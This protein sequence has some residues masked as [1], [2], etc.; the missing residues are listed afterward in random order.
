MDAR[1]HHVVVVLLLRVGG[2]DEAVA[3]GPRTGQ[4]NV[5]AYNRQLGRLIHHDRAKPSFIASHELP[6]DQDPEA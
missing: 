1:R 2:E 3:V 4:A 5:K 6:L